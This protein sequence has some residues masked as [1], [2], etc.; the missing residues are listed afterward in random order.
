[1]VSWARE[2]HLNGAL[3]AA[4]RGRSAG[5]SSPHPKLRE[6]TC[7]LR[8]AFKTNCSGTSWIWLPSLGCCGHC[9][10]A[11]GQ[12]PGLAWH[13][14]RRDVSIEP[15]VAAW[16]HYCLGT[17]LSKAQLGTRQAFPVTGQLPQLPLV[18]KSCFHCPWKSFNLQAGETGRK[19]AG[20]LH[21][22]GGGVAGRRGLGSG[23][24]CAAPAF[25]A[26]FRVLGP[27]TYPYSFPFVATGAFT[28]SLSLCRNI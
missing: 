3:G 25:W 11:P 27:W 4:Q 7:A 26:L 2:S 12:G 8:R 20:V 28:P 17:S 21:L 22:V 1:M 19:G 15:F 14:G 10:Q 13:T 18:V 5:C 16:G 9:E 23:G 24:A 6:Q